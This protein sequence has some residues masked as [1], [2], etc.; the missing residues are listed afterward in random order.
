MNQYKLLI[1]DEDISE[2]VELLASAKAVWS[3]P[4]LLTLT[5][6]AESPSAAHKLVLQKTGKRKK[7][8]A[9]RCYAK[10]CRDY[11]PVMVRA[12]LRALKVVNHNRPE[13]LKVLLKQALH[14][15]TSEK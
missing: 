10:A 14:G 7:A 15:E 5:R 8:E 6:S 3:D 12:A 1:T 2:F 9:A 11:M 13:E 4:E